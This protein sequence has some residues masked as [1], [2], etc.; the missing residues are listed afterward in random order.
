MS[1][2][3]VTESPLWVWRQGAFTSP[4]ALIGFSSG[5]VS[6]DRVEGWMPRRR[7]EKNLG[8]MS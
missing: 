6:T 4:S 8:R 7:E 5:L 2:P 3:Q 1:K